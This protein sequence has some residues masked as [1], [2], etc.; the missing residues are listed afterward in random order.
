MPTIGPNNG[1]A[2]ASDGTVGTIAVSNPTNCAGSDNSY[3]TD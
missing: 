2:F 3:A 1:V